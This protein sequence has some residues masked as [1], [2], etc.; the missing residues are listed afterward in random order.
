M[1]V[2]ETQYNKMQQKRSRLDSDNSDDSVQ[3]LSSPSSVA[4]SLSNYQNP[5]QVKAI[6]IEEKLERIDLRIEKLGHAVMSLLKRVMQP[7][8][9]DHQCASDDSPI[10]L[11]IRDSPSKLYPRYNLDDLDFDFED[12]A[13]EDFA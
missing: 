5:N 9:Q 10:G 12:F 8:R 4:S 13:R 6:E 11:Q 2:S 1:V 3:E 7:E